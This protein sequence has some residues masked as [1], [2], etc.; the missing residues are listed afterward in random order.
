[1]MKEHL[2]YDNLPPKQLHWEI[3]LYRVCLCGRW[4]LNIKPIFQPPSASGKSYLRR[5]VLPAGLSLRQLAPEA[6]AL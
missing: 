4:Q 3:G 5:S 6:I 2:A 1:M